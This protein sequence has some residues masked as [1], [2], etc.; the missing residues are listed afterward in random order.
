MIQTYAFALQVQSQTL[1]EKLAFIPRFVRRVEEEHLPDTSVS[2]CNRYHFVEMVQNL[3]WNT[4][5]VRSNEIDRFPVN[6]ALFT[7]NSTHSSVACYFLGRLLSV[8]DAVALLDNTVMAALL[9]GHIGF[10]FPHFQS[11]FFHSTKLVPPTII[12]KGTDW[13]RKNSESFP[14]RIA[15]RIW[16]HRGAVKLEFFPF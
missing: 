9:P 8:A 12:I 6:L 14:P 11:T 7:G 4:S 16:L 13:N 1:I 2:V 10:L 5:T 3:A 15:Q